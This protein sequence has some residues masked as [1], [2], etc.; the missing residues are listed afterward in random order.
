VRF[1][2]GACAALAL[3]GC[4]QLATRT[5]LVPPER[6]AALLPPEP[7]KVSAASQELA[8]YYRSLQQDL[9][10]R[11]LLRTDGGGPDT[12]Y[13]AD[14]LARNFE[15]IAFYDEYK[16]GNE[17]SAGAMGRWPGPVRITTAFGPSVPEAQRQQDQ[18]TIS[19]YV[20]RLARIT[21]HPVRTVPEQGNLLVLVAGKDDSSFV[22]E[23]AREM[24][25]AIRAEDLSILANPDRTYFCLVLA[26]G[27]PEDP[28]AYSRGVVLIRAEH[29]DLVR[30]SCV[31]EELAQGLGLR[32]D[33]PRA[34][35][36]IFNDDDE[37]ALL[38]SHD[39]KLLT[40]LYD[41]RL[42]IGM[43][44]E[45]ARPVTRSIARELMGQP[46]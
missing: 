40:M 9:V 13:D 17:R 20:R 35:P 29:P 30:K 42:R 37:F 39:E 14:K 44:A 34:R 27:P 8:V 6:P 24:L 5:S 38:T 12:P 45:E 32:N 19:A 36:S 7:V 25:P 33:S 1:A 22:I 41:P 26:G 21:G 4:D 43:S 3:A 46:L 10:T 31:H 18:D 11:G 2:A 15:A 28:L 16:R 23:K